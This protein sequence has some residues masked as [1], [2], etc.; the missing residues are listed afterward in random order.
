MKTNGLDST[1]ISHLMDSIENKWK[2][3]VQYVDEINTNQDKNDLDRRAFEELSTLRDVYEGYN[4]YIQNAES[5]SLDDVQKLTLQLETNK[6][7]KK[8]KN[9]FQD[10]KL[11]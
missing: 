2:E 7:N 8:L 6:V 5:L 9:F 11:C 3:N 1:D 10:F 4:K